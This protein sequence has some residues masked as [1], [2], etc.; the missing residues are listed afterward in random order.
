MACPWFYP[1]ERLGAARSI[2]PLGDAW[3]GECRASG[4]E[5][6]VPDRARLLESCNMGYARPACP[7]FPENGGPDAV[8]FAVAAHREGRVRLDCVH[9]K[10][11][12]PFGRAALDW[13]L[14][15]GRFGAP[16]AD[17]LLARQ[18]WAYLSSYLLR[19]P[20]P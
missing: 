18:A 9:E 20:H 1:L 13:D 14:A 19:K 2:M 5:A 11:Y 17:A 8:R 15:G 6:S 4:G 10:D 7:R 3:E 16:P 12:L